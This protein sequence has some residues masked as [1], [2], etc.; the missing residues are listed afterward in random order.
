MFEGTVIEARSNVELSQYLKRHVQDYAEGLPNTPQ[1]LLVM[2]AD[3]VEPE[4]AR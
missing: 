3:V 1:R 4:D 2:S